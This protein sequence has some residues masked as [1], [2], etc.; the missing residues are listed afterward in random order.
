[1]HCSRT[2]SIPVYSRASL[3]TLRVY[4]HS[5]RST[6]AHSVPWSVWSDLCARSP[7]PRH[8]DCCYYMRARPTRGTHTR[9]QTQGRYCTNAA[10]QLA[11]INLA[12]YGRECVYAVFAR[13]C[14]V[15]V[16]VLVCVY[17]CMCACAS[18]VN[19]GEKKHCSTSAHADCRNDCAIRR[20][21]RIKQCLNMQSHVVSN[22]DHIAFEATPHTH[23]DL[24]D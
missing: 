22:V 24:I 16:Y 13:E 23:N 3:S 2:G 7:N 12:L 9:T 11:R 8:E 6:R 17:S 19:S 5:S 10:H 15:C 1:M 21:E 20:S 18:C 14:V 4:A